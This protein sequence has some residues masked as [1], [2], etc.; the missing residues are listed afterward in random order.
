M[1]VTTTHTQNSKR[2]ITMKRYAIHIP[3]W[4]YSMTCYGYN[5]RDAR[6][7]FRDQHGFGKRLP[8]GTEVWEVSV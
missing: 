8:N 7:R 2:I 5:E 4:C 6:S 1:M 3:G